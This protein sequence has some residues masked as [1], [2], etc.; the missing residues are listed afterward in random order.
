MYF[1]FQSLIVTFPFT[2]FLQEKVTKGVKIQMR[3]VFMQRRQSYERI[4]LLI[5]TRSWPRPIQGR[6]CA[7]AAAQ[8]TIN[9]QL[10]VPQLSLMTFCLS[11]NNKF[12]SFLT[13]TIFY[14]SFES[15]HVPTWRVRLL[16]PVL[17][18]NRCF[19]SV[20]L[21]A[22]FESDRSCTEV[23]TGSLTHRGWKICLDLSHDTVMTFLNLCTLVFILFEA[24]VE[25]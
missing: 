18:V 9:H 11:N 1:P 5:L 2:R 7:G 24:Q 10:K 21:L 16:R 17:Y 20:R 4:D 22:W 12:I 23:L 6:A 19:G 25:D 15:Y 13:E 14:S 8:A 3:C